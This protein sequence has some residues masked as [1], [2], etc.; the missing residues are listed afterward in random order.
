MSDKYLK[1][2]LLYEIE[3]NKINLLLVYKINDKILIVNDSTNKKLIKSYFKFSRTKFNKFLGE[4]IKIKEYLES[5]DL[6]NEIEII[7]K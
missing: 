6:Y 1:H 3:V 2:L 7:I 4:F 5:H